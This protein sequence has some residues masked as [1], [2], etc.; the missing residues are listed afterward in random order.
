MLDDRALTKLKYQE[1]TGSTQE[2]RQLQICH[3]VR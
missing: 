1:A 3:L 2:L